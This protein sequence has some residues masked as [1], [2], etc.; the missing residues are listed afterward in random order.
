MA[1]KLHIVVPDGTLKLLQEQAKK[2]G[3]TKSSLARKILL[4]ALT[5]KK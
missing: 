1:E 5:I 2:E 3:H 4:N